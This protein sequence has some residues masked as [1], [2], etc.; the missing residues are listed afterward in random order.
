MVVLAVTWSLVTVALAL[1]TASGW[2]RRPR[3]VGGRRA[4]GALI[5]AASIS[6]TTWMWL[7]L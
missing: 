4:I 2:L 1:W 3:Q 5:L 7:S 6:L